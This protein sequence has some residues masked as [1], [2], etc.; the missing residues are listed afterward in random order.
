MP[1]GRLMTTIDERIVAAPPH[2]I[3]ELAW[4]VEDWP[5]H[6]AHYRWVRFR[7]RRS[8][9]GG[10]VEMS[11]NR[12]FGIFDWPTYWM[13]EM[14]VVRPGENGSTSAS[15]RF[16][17]VAGIT[18]GMDVE[19][20]FRPEGVGTVVRIVHVWDGPRWPIVGA[21]AARALIGPVFVHGIA[22]RTLAGLGSAAEAVDQQRSRA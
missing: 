7:E 12:P 19:W 3:F 8:D 20:S 1:A 6:L 21:I 5:R 15:V 11:A 9:G 2:V 16:R 22:S 4:R 14:E 17:H 18:R 13:S 10:L